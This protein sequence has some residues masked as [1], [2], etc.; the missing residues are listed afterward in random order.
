MARRKYTTIDPRLNRICIDVTHRMWERRAKE[1]L[2]EEMNAVAEDL[3]QKPD[4]LVIHDKD[5]RATTLMHIPM[6]V[7]IRNFYAGMFG[8]YEEEDRVRETLKAAIV[9]H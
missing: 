4:T 5:G 2:E 9:L 6:H 3:A 8:D 1:R 7:R